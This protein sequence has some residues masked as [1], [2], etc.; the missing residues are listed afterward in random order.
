MASLLLFSGVASAYC[1]TDE[2]LAPAVGAASAPHPD[3]GGADDACPGLRTPD[4][5]DAKHCVQWDV[6]AA[7]VF[8]TVH[9]VAPAPETLIS[10]APRDPIVVP[11]FQRFPRLLN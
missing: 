3:T 4:K 1:A 11:V 8:L 5:E 9:K 2:G 6:V 10:V 7:A